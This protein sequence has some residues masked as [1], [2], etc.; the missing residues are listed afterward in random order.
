MICRRGTG[1]QQI[2][3]SGNTA[4]AQEEFETEGDRWESQG[5]G[6][7]VGINNQSPTSTGNTKT[8]EL[9]TFCKRPEGENNDCVEGEG[10]NCYG[11]VHDYA[12][13][14]CAA[15]HGHLRGMQGKVHRVKIV[16]KALVAH[17]SCKG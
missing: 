12:S 11:G 3:S 13:K 4:G 15:G 7:G 8:K 2:C 16:G 6:S 17:R 1:Q 5:C 9:E 10:T 14:V